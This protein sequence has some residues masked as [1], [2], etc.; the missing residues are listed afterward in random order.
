MSLS[1]L[2]ICAQE[3]DRFGPRGE[4]HA[5]QVAALARR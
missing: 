1:L 5:W 4:L 2:K 3:I